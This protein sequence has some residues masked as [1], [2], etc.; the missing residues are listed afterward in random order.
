MEGGYTERAFHGSLE[1]L[2]EFHHGLAAIV[3]V[4]GEGWRFWIEFLELFVEQRRLLKHFPQNALAFSS[5]NARGCQEPISTPLD[6]IFVQWMAV[7]YRSIAL[8]IDTERF[9]S[10][11]G[12]GRSIHIF[13]RD[14]RYRDIQEP[15][16][17]SQI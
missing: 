2:E 9:E 8:A 11:R 6:A 4:V 3:V 14:V 15:P 12:E 17:D 7:L 1:Q 5:I 16:A 13:Q 10:T